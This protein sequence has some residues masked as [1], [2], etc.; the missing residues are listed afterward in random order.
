MHQRVLER[1]E[2]MWKSAISFGNVKLFMMCSVKAALTK[3]W[4]QRPNYRVLKRFLTRKFY[5][6]IDSKNEKKQHLYNQASTK[7]VRVIAHLVSGG[8]RVKRSI[9]LTHLCFPVRL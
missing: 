6:V 8:H 5:L 9:R 7:E 4:K 3:G 1:K 2:Q